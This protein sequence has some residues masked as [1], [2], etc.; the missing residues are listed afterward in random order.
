MPILVKFIALFWTL[1]EILIIFYLHLCIS[2]IEGKRNFE[3][4]YIIICIALSGFLIFILFF[5]DHLLGIF[6]NF[7]RQYNLYI[8]ES[9]LWKFFCT[10]WAALEGII[11]IYVMAIYGALKCR[12]TNKAIAD[13]YFRIAGFNFYHLNIFIILFFLTLYI[14]YEYNLIFLVVKYSLRVDNFYNLSLLYRKICAVFN[15]IFDGGVA[16][17]GYKTY[18][19]LKKSEMDIL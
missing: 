18:S 1:A 6:V 10:L 7:N 17:L 9:G 16:L 13:E 8:Y 14:L 5:G 15:I 3:N 2:F 12:L 19:L 4:T 11:M